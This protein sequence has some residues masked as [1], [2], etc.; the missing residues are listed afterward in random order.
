[1]P[2]GAL[3]LQQARVVDPVL[4][5]VARG[6]RNAVRAWPDLFP[7]VEVLARGGKMI[8][9]NPDDF[10]KVETIRAH[11]AVIERAEFGYAGKDYAC[12]QRAL[13]GVVPRE[14]VEEAAAV[15]GINMQSVTVQQT[16]NVL[17]LQIEVAAANLATTASNYPSGH[18]L[19]LTGNKRWD[20]D[21]STP[22]KAI[23]N[24]VQKIRQGIGQQPNVLILGYPVFNA[25]QHHED[26][27][28]RIKYT[29]S[30]RQGGEPIINAE[31]LASYFGVAKVIVG[32]AM[33]GEAGDFSDAWGKNAVLA[34]SNV[35]PLASMGSPSFGYTYRLQGYPMV[36]PGWFDENTKSW[37]YPITT[38]DTPAIVGGAAGY[39]LT[40]VVD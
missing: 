17:D 26:V 27:I 18:T 25:L 12:V 19:G 1:M 35:T 31:K 11:G 39:L 3:N 22:N 7:P 23:A 36:E 14:R 8:E 5:T 32:A 24:G 9:F 21:A 29:E 15:P 2:P 28:D 34:Y 4:S 33:T 10:T 6:Y 37:V 30:L 20:N 40:A 16:M 38:E 13:A